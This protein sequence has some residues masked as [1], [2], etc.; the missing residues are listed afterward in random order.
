MR[1]SAAYWVLLATTWI[2]PGCTSTQV[3]QAT[4]PRSTPSATAPVGDALYV[5]LQ[6]L[7]PPESLLAALPEALR[8]KLEDSL[9][10]LDASLRRELV[11]PD[12]QALHIRPLM[13][14]AAGGNELAAYTALFSTAAAGDEL[15]V[16]ADP[17]ASAAEV[18]GLANTL[19]QRAAQHVLQARRGDVAP[20]VT[21]RPEVVGEIA[22]AANILGDFAL[23]KAAIDALAELSDSPTVRLRRIRLLCEQLDWRAAT[24]QLLSEKALS[25]AE[26]REAETWIAAARAVASP[27]AESLAAKVEQARLALSLDRTVRASELLAGLDKAAN[28]DLSYAT[29]RARAQI[30]D[31][32]CPGLRRELANAYLC[33]AA[34]RAFRTSHS[35]AELETAW[36][37]GKGRDATA[38]DSYLGLVHVT[39]LMYGFDNG[40]G[41]A[42]PE[43][44]KTTLLNMEQRATEALAVSAHLRAVAL[45]AKTLRLAFSASVEATDTLAAIAEGDRK[46]LLAEAQELANKGPKEPFDQAAILAVTGILAQVDDGRPAL[47][48]LIG[49]VQ[50]ELQPPFGALLLWN[51]L[52]SQDPA[53]FN[54]TRNYYGELAQNPAIESYERSRWLLLWAEAEQHLVPSEHS[55]ATLQALCKQLRAKGV[56]LELQLRA[57]INLAGL[58]ARRGD[59]VKAAEFLKDI[60]EVPRASVSSRQEQELLIAATGYHLVLEALAAP[61]SLPARAGELSQLLQT[62]ATASAASPALQVWLALWRGELETL[63]ETRDCRGNTACERRARRARG[64]DRKLLG[65]SVGRRSA[66]LLELGVL[67]IGGVQVE[68]QY[69]RGRLIPA[70]TVDS[71]F[72]LAHMPTIA[73]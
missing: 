34:W 48:Q 20:G 45:M 28:E 41:D 57:A 17:A 39:Q 2:A 5:K 19:S 10:K 47:T 36:Q 42:S 26:R 30:G 27:G 13:H 69:Q 70:I 51:Q 3:P 63:I 24:E 67:A 38:V 60:A 37:S 64:I 11:N 15:A 14:L 43:S 16:L 12:G 65:E 58:E 29:T 73:K 59:F 9:D 49:L 40:A 4:A 68:F 72:L 25:V 50:T 53:G 35:L 7:P 56:P 71:S 22:A 21:R 32:P 46:Q 52:A 55:L 33:R 23:E 31:G 6:A 54:A 8:S 1:I 66:A 61:D 44:F 18:V 62:V